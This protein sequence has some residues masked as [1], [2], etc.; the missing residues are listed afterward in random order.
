MEEKERSEREKMMT[1]RSTLV[2]PVSS[3]SDF[4]SSFSLSSSPSLLHFPLILASFFYFFDGSLVMIPRSEAAVMLMVMMMMIE[5][6]K[7]KLPL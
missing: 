3:P 4:F 5:R 1:I 6:R 2:V 7:G